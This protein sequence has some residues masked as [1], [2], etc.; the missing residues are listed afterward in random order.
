MGMSQA[1]L[2]LAP[3]DVLLKMPG[4]TDGSGDFHDSQLRVDV[5]SRREIPWESDSDRDLYLAEFTGDPAQFCPRSVLR[6]VLARAAR[7]NAFPKLGYELEFTL[8]N[9][10]PETLSAKGFE[11]D[12]DVEATAVITDAAS[13]SRL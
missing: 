7:M 10:T 5:E 2:A 8:F 9:E 4:V 3:T 11:A 1:Q 12:T 6:Q 13:V